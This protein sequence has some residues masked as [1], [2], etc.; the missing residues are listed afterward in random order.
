MRGL[1]KAKVVFVEAHA[2][3]VCAVCNYTF[4]AFPGTDGLIF[5]CPKCNR[6]FK[7][8]AKIKPLTKE[9]IAS[10][11]EHRTRNTSNRNSFNDLD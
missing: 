8:S 11:E 10:H 1:D 6:Y 7:L 4:D 5:N 2:E 9:E 3:M